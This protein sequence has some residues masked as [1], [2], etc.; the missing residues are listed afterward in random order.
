MYVLY[1]ELRVFY[2][3]LI[4]HYSLHKQLLMYMCCCLF[5]TFG[6]YLRLPEFLNSSRLEA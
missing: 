6:S 5:H 1:F 2:R 4:L 3:A